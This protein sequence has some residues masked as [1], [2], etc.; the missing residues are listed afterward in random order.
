MEAVD[1][2]LDFFLLRTSVG[3]APL[4]Q[5]PEPGKRNVLAERPLL[6]ERHHAV[7]RDEHH[8]GSYRIG[9]MMERKLLPAHQY[10]AA[11]CRARAGDAFEKLILSLPLER[12]D[13]ENFA[14]KK[15]EGHIAEERSV[16][17]AADFE[18]GL[19]TSSFAAE[20]R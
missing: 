10:S 19:V 7:R 6:Q 15:L 4:L 8:A 14:G 11:F 2:G 5:G 13:P 16:F 20:F 9:R 17:E 12:G 18:R 3:E 1:G